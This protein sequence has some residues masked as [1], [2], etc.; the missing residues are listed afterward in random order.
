MKSKSFP[1]PIFCCCVSRKLDRHPISQMPRQLFVIFF[2]FFC[3]PIF[4]V[5]ISRVVLVRSQVAKCPT[6]LQLIVNAIMRLVAPAVHWP[7][8]LVVSCYLRHR[9]QIGAKKSSTQ[10]TAYIRSLRL[11]STRLRPCI[12]TRSYLVY[13]S[14]NIESGYAHPRAVSRCV[15]CV[16]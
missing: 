6:Q 9:R 2:F 1:Q 10:F 7:C 5:L 14:S 11:T 13:T 16:R 4:I 3:Q 8:R 15:T 12:L